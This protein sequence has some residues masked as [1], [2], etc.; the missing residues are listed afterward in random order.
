MGKAILLHFE[1]VIYRCDAWID[2]NYIGSHEGGYTPFSFDINPFIQNGREHLLIVRVAALSKKKVVDGMQIQHAP[3]SKQ[4]WYYVFGGIWGQ[5]YL[6]ACPLLSCDSLHID[7][8]LHRE[9]AQ[10]EI[11]LR[12]RFGQHRQ[13]SL[14]F[15]VLDPQERVVLEQDHKVS[16]LPGLTSFLY[17]LNLPRPLA[18]SFDQPNL[19]RLETSLIDETGETDQR[20]DHFGM[21]DFTVQ[22]G[23]LLPQ[24]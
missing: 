18:W 10:V 22:S 9:Q 14:R 2:G 7:P 21:R 19:Y 1:G 4:S 3:L 13:S 23:T 20:V 8:N 5:V 15:R 6:E 12:N 24:W 17:T 11:R 16:A